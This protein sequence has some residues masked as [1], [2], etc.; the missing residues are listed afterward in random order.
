MYYVLSMRGCKPTYYAKDDYDIALDRY[1]YMK[2]YFSGVSLTKASH[3]KIIKD[4]VV[5][6]RTI[7]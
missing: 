6:K 7:F 2:K 5:T 3:N 1:F 4:V